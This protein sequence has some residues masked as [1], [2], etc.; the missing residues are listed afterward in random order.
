MA[1]R[2]FIFFK[3]SVFLF[4]CL[5]LVDNSVPIKIT[6]VHYN[7]FHTRFQ[8]IDRNGQDC[9][10]EENEKQEC[11]GGFARLKSKVC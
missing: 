3:F 11:F 4:T 5:I 9:S 1:R 2:S 10:Q 8:P 7:D 6:I